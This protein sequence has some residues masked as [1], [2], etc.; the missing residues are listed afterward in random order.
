MNE[1][2]LGSEFMPQEKI[3]E[4]VKAPAGGAEVIIGKKVYKFKNIPSDLISSDFNKYIEDDLEDAINI[5]K[6]L[7]ELYKEDIVFAN[8]TSLLQNFKCGN[9]S[10]TRGKLSVNFSILYSRGY[11]K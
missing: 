7:D 3:E 2:L 9:S 8:I 10:I 5:L 11:F 6:D 4:K 1:Q